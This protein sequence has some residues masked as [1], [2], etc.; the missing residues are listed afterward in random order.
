MTIK[1]ILLNILNFIK[2]IYL[3]LFTFMIGNNEKKFYRFYV[4]AWTI[5]LL[6]VPFV[7]LIITISHIKEKTFELSNFAIGLLA[8]LLLAI[9]S[10]Y[11]VKLQMYLAGK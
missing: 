3:K 1:N 8:S 6:L 4:H 7:F 2:R 10:A 11:L 9:L 5:L